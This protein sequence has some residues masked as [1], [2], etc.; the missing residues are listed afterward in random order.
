MAR[1][2]V[3]TDDE[4]IRRARRVFLERGYGART[5]E[6]AAAVGLTW[7]AVVLRFGGKWELFERAMADPQQGS[8]MFQ[9]GIASAAEL[10][11]L[12]HRLAADLR[13]QW[14]RQLQLRIATGHRAAED[15]PDRLADLLT[16]ALADLAGRGALRSD[17]HARPLAQIVVSLLVGEAARRFARCERVPAN[18][19][20]L[21]D[22]V[23]T[24]L[25]PD[26][27]H[28]AKVPQ[29]SPP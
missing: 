8:A 10:R 19:P 25:Q 18:D 27:E 6:I 21:A 24:L 1:H 3:L 17:I 13:E 5:R 29:G 4:I 11:T 15:G 12:L 7:G 22:R 23:M 20:E 16:P 9:P 28:A 2:P 26:F 14:P